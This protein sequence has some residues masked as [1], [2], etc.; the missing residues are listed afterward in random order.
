MLPQQSFQGMYTFRICKVLLQVPLSL[1]AR[2]EF[3]CPSHLLCCFKLNTPHV[4]KSYWS[5][6]LPGTV[7]RLE[8]KESNLWEERP[9]IR[10]KGPIVW[11][12]VLGMELTSCY[13]PLPSTTTKRHGWQWPFGPW[14][15]RTRRKDTNNKTIFTGFGVSLHH[16][17]P[18]QPHTTPSPLLTTFCFPLTSAAL[19]QKYSQCQVRLHLLSGVCDHKEYK[20]WQTASPVAQRSCLLGLWAVDRKDCSQQ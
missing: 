8:G 10:S 9:E 17:P 6:S 11:A 5:M 1:W 12:E 13:L 19:M 18:P 3:H 4:G 2:R 7:W 16:W 14:C 15:K 20:E